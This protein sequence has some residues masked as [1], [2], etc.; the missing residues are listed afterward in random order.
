[1]YPLYKTYG[2]T[3]KRKSLSNRLLHPIELTPCHT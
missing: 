3:F 1:M 2:I